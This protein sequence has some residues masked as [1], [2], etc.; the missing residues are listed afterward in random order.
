MCHP[1]TSLTY[2]NI[3]THA[4][5]QETIYPRITATTASTSKSSSPPTNSASPRLITNALPE[6]LLTPYS[7]TEEGGGGGING[8]QPPWGEGRPS[9]VAPSQSFWKKPSGG[10]ERGTTRSGD[11]GTGGHARPVSRSKKG[12]CR[13]GDRRRQN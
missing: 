1:S 13:P 7:C 12:R 10:R 2:T 11:C 8:P 3:H 9:E 4:C 6:S 5:T